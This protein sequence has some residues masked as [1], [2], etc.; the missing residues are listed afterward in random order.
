MI[1]E[2]NTLKNNKEFLLP[3]KQQKNKLEQKPKD[4]KNNYMLNK[5]MKSQECKS[6]YNI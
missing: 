6:I 2:W 5:L 3:N 4:L 1:Q